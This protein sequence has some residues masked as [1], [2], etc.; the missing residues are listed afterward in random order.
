MDISV[1]GLNV[2]IMTYDH[3]QP[4]TRRVLEDSLH[5]IRFT[6]SSPTEQATLSN[7]AHPV[8]GMAGTVK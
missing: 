5:S 3:H 4:E 6:G 2:T 1:F 8:D 7:N